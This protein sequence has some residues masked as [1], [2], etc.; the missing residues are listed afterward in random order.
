MVLKEIKTET[1]FDIVMIQP[2]KLDSQKGHLRNQRNP[3]E[4]LIL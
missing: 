4:T 3:K 1:V 2:K